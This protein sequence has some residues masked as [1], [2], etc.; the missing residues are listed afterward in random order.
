MK[1]IFLNPIN[2]LILFII[3]LIMLAINYN[4]NIERK[5]EYNDQIQEIC[6]GNDNFAEENIIKM[7]E[8]IESGEKASYLKFNNVYDYLEDQT[9]ML[10]LPLLFI[11]LIAS[12]YKF[13]QNFHSG[14]IKKELTN[15]KYK[16]FITKE[17]INSIGTI[18][19]LFTGYF[20]IVFAI[21]YL[22]SEVVNDINYSKIFIE[23]VNTSLYIIF[24]ILVAIILL[25]YI[26]NIVIYI[27]ISLLAILSLSLAIDTVSSILNF[28]DSFIRPYDGGMQFYFIPQVILNIFLLFIMIKTYK[29]NSEFTIEN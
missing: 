25:K 12:T 17:F 13:H 1:K 11:F 6:L 24:S 4:V 19:F 26:K 18:L 20:V 14:F 10:F 8:R 23:Y 21:S 22:T 29:N 5:T 7:C 16:K 28:T 3:L 15:E 27:F 9:R 2:Y